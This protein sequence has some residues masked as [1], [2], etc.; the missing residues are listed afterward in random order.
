MKYGVHSYLFTDRWA[1]DRLGILDTA[2]ELGFDAFEI[3]TGDDVE[4]TPGLTRRRAEALGLALTVGPGGYWPPGYDL[5]ADDP[6]DR[7]HGLAWH[8]RQVDQAV[9]IGAV[10][11]CGAL[12][13][14]PGAV[15]RR[16]PPA[17]EYPR[18]A[19]GLYRLAEYA[20]GGGVAVVLEPMSRFR[21]HLVNTAE[22]ATRLINLAGHPNLGVLLDTYHMITEVRDY[23]AAMRAAGDRLWGVHACE[24][25][26]G[27]PGGGLVPWDAVF[28]ALHDLDFDGYLFLETYNS[29]IGDFAY[30][31]GVF[32][33][34][35]PDGYA[36][37]RDGLSF[38]KRG[39]SRSCPG[40]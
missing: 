6:A 9:E 20:C 40:G 23:A 7:R 25:D 15:R 11:Y 37:A 36:F 14:Q 16:R 28:A 33:N 17:D 32:Q 31:R 12:Y 30:R 39:G 21:T 38:L 5:S 35:C 2:R 4:F 26:R 3:S 24:N 19:E 1:D 8:Q 34:P 10:A 13:G 18:T 22:Q 27:L 29:S